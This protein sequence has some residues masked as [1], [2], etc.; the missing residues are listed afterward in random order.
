MPLGKAVVR[1][2]AGERVT[3]CDLSSFWRG[4]QSLSAG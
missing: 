4:S 1:D 3:P 2:G